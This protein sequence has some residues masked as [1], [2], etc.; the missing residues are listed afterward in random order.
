[1]IKIILFLL[2]QIDVQ[3]VNKNSNIKARVY[4]LTIVL[5]IHFTINVKS[6]YYKKKTHS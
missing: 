6:T 5:S 1:M 2:F 4:L 3:N